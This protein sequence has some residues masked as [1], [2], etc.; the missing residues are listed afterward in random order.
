MDATTVT[1]FSP[2]ILSYDV[3]L[4]Y[5]TTTVPTVTATTTDANASYVINDATALPGTTSVEVTAEDGITI[6]TY[7]INFILEEAVPEDGAPM[8]VHDE[9][10]HSV[11]SI[12]SDSYTNLEN[13]NFNPSWGQSTQVVVDEQIGGNN[14]LVYTN[15]NYQGTNLGSAD[16]SPQD[17]SNSDY[18]HIDFWTPNAT[19]LNF[20]LIS[21]TSG[22]I[23]YALTITNNEWVSVNIPLSYFSN[24]GLDLTDIYQFKID[25][26]DGSTTV[27]FD[28]WYF[29][30]VIEGSDASLSDLQVDGETIDG[31]SPSIFEY[32]VELAA[33]TTIIPT[34]TATTSD[35]DATYVVNDAS[36]IPGTTEVVIT[37][38]DEVTILTYLVNFLLPE[39]M[40]VEAAP[41][42]TQLEENVISMFSDAYTDVDVDTWLT[43]WSVAVLEE[44]EIQSNPTKKYSSLDYAGIETVGSPMD[45]ESADMVYLHIDFWTPN[46]TAFRIKLVDFGGDGF[47]G[48]NDTEAEIEFTPVLS[49]WNLL[50]IPLEDFAD[51]NMSDINQIVISSNPSGEST[52]F[53][54]NVFFYKDPVG[55]N[56]VAVDELSIYPN[57]TSDSW[58]ISTT[59]V[60]HEIQIFDLSG[61]VVL[62]LQPEQ[63]GIINID[64]SEL[65]RGIYILRASGLSTR[66]FKLIKE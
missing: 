43:D 16:G 53:I 18:F 55:I 20:F 41:T 6:L 34:V 63:S 37:A 45:L 27:Y 14:T 58:F 60:I 47:G 23:P 33:G 24:Q 8:P 54:D 35:A 50:D 13:T 49:E 11:F 22:E 44:I 1:G 9:G 46:S 31:F 21:Q 3:E 26:G 56:D 17:F 40:P 15:L 65:H 39:P 30:K 48:G 64:A 51:M 32:D 42:P 52:V 25:G 19:A 66:E 61:R 10:L 38:Q 28:N 5:G 36:A 4:P 62:S 12:Y 59:E 2:S 7:N 57:P 29:W